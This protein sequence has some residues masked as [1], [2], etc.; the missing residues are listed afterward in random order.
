MSCFG[1]LRIRDFCLVGFILAEA[2]LSG[3][4]WF[5]VDGSR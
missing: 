5:T 1:E 2:P 3:F 4:S